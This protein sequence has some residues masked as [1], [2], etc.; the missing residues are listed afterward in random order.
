MFSKAF[1]KAALER[2]VKSA[3]QF[4]LAAWGSV[5]FTDVG[6]V[7]TVAP[8]VGWAVVFGAGLS[9][10]TSVAS[11]PFGDEGPSLGGEKLSDAPPA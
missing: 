4:G 10:L 7:T 5:V 8:A 3:A 6:D 11:A 1:W 2:A 9:V